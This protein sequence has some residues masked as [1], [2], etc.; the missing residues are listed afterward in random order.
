MQSIITF[1]TAIRTGWAVGRRGDGGWCLVESGV[2]VFDTR[3]GESPG[4]RFMRFRS[5]LAELWRLSGPFDLAVYELAHHRGGAATEL[6]VGFTTRIAE[7]A[8]EHGAEHASVHSGTLKKAITGSGGAG[9]PEMMRAAQRIFEVIPK[10]DNE[11]DALCLL[12]YAID[13]F[14]GGKVATAPPRA[15]AQLF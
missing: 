6:A 11:A 14:G 12:R 1:D 15:P 7:W 3:R 13:N 4:L 9:K 5:W 2:Q 8:A 10:D